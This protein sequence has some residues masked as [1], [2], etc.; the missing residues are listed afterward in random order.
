[1][2]KAGYGKPAP[3]EVWS[4]NATQTC[5]SCATGGAMMLHSYCVD[6]K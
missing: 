6:A 5:A 1:M 4:I 2:K 3:S